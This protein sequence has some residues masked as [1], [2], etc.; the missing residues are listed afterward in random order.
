[1]K[2]ECVREKFRRASRRF[3]TNRAKTKSPRTY[4]AVRHLI[5]QEVLSLT[6]ARAIVKRSGLL[7]EM[8]EYFDHRNSMRPDAR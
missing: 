1:M 2:G 6:T 5:R 7:D 3:E 4:D 8:G